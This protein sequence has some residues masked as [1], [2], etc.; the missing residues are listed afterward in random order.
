MTFNEA[1]VSKI[2][3]CTRTHGYDFIAMKKALV[4]GISGQDG[5]YL[6]KLLLQNGYDVCGTSRDAQNIGGPRQSLWSSRFSKP[7][8]IE[9]PLGR[10]HVIFGPH[11][12]THSRVLQRSGP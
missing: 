1:A 6:A 5:A 8:E 2:S 9:S 10:I 12:V 3:A 11:V 7:A 4:T